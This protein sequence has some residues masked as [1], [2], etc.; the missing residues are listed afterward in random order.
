MVVV[1][2]HDLAG[3][4]PVEADCAEATRDRLRELGR[5]GK[6]RAVSPAGLH[7]PRRQ[8]LE[9]L[10]RAFLD[11]EL[12]RLVRDDLVAHVAVPA[13]LTP[14]TRLDRGDDLRADVVRNDSSLDVNEV[15][16]R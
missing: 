5:E 13:M 1:L 16:Q 10:G 15:L 3:G 6:L 8:Q 14:L 2:A 11:L 9:V 4:I 7:H 12:H